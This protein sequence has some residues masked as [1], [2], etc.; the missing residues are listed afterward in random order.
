MLRSQRLSLVLSLLSFGGV[1]LASRVQAQY[2]DLGLTPQNQ[3]GPATVTLSPTGTSA[4]GAYTYGDGGTGVPL[5]AQTSYGS[6]YVL[7]NSTA[8]V[9]GG[10]IY[11]LLLDSGGGGGGS[12]TANISGGSIANVRPDSN[13]TANISGGSIGNVGPTGE[14]LTNVSGGTIGTLRSDVY[15]RVNVTGGSIGTLKAANMFLS[16]APF[17]II[18]VQGGTIG[19]IQATNLSTVDVG[20]GNIASFST[21]DTSLIDIFG[22]GLTETF[23]GTFSNYTE[24]SITGT[25]YSGDVVNSTYFDYGGTLEFNNRVPPAIPEASTTV[26]LGLLLALGM[27]GLVVSA[28][29]KRAQSPL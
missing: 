22:T 19:A 16:Y 13:S 12:S 7:G 11:S 21:A 18:N 4:S 8:N 17:D 2:L 24:Y 28:R 3:S 6:W 25:L 15:S 20:G 9:S 26:S 23:L 5:S 29:R 27:G 14:S 10:S 1:T